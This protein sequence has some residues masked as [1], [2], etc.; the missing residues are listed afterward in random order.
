MQ[1]CVSNVREFF[2]RMCN[3]DFLAHI[4]FYL[5]DFLTDIYWNLLRNMKAHWTF[6]SFESQ[7]PFQ[8]LKPAESCL[9][10]K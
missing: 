8:A 3:G 1:S 10:D 2:A 9:N 6:K 4:E 7:K 5:D